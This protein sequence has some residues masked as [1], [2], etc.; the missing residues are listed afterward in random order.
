MLSVVNKIKG[1]DFD[2]LPDYYK[3]LEAINFSNKKKRFI[4]ILNEGYGHRILVDIISEEFKISQSFACGMRG[5]I[6]PNAEML[7][8]INRN[9]LKK[10]GLIPTFSVLPILLGKEAKVIPFYNDAM[11]S[12]IKDIEDRKVQINHNSVSFDKNKN[13]IVIPDS[14]ARIPI[15]K[16]IPNIAKII[17]S[18]IAENNKNATQS[19]L[20]NLFLEMLSKFRVYIINCVALNK[21]TLIYS[22][23]ERIEFDKESIYDLIEPD[24]LVLLSAGVENIDSSVFIKTAL[25]IRHVK[26]D[27]ENKTIIETPLSIHEID[28]LY[29][30]GKSY[31][32]I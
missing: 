13:I 29:S 16:V 8:V 9:P 22:P 3:D 2:E 28:K 1:S 24:I 21:Q 17:I 4:E 10:Y 26:E 12:Y 5:F 30:L 15:T 32:V 27:S 7:N 20:T 23:V 6:N 25:S 11:I 19:E 31:A 14:G 18:L